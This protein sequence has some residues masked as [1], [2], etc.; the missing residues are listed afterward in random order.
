MPDLLSILTSL[1]W[2][3]A[4]ALAWLAGEFGQRFTGLPRVTF[5][6][7]VGFALASGQIGILPV[8]NGGAALVAADIAFGLMLFE[9]GYR[10]NLRW[11]RAN[12]W[13]GVIPRRMPASSAA[14][15]DCTMTALAISSSIRATGCNVSSG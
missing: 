9:L 13:L 14:R 4:I 7:L 5:Y 8:P 10:I 6:G 2:P 12:P 11:F 15:F 3:M 1:A